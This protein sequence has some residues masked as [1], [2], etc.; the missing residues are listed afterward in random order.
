MHIRHWIITGFFSLLSLSICF[1]QRDQHEIQHKQKELQKLRDD[2]QK[3]EKRIQ[4]SDKREQVT[5]DRLD[6]LEHQSNLIRQLVQKLH[7]EELQLTTEIDTA[8]AAIASLENQLHFLQSH[9]ANYVRS[10]YKN[11]RSV[12]HRTALFFKI[13]QS[14]VYPYSVSQ[15]ILRTACKGFAGNQCKQIGTGTKKLYTAG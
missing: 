8:R 9:Y 3:Y 15:T 5:L 13:H 12:R 14:D 1:A 2:I 11:G 10:V 4:E 7:D 6:D